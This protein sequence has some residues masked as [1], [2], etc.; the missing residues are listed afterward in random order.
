MIYF[1][2]NYLIG[3]CGTCGSGTCGSMAMH[4]FV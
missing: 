3:T 2:G 1:I 4:A